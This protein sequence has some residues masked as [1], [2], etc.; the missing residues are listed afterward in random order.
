MASISSGGLDVQAIVAQLMV[1]EQKKLDGLNKSYTDDKVKISLYGKFKSIVDNLKTASDN[2]GKAYETSAYKVTSSDADKITAT[3]DVNKNN[4]IYA[5]KHT[6]AVTKL[7][8]AGVYSSASAY[9]T[10]SAAMNVT[11]NLTFT[12]GSDNFTIDVLATDTLEMVRDKINNA[13]SGAGVKASILSTTGGG[14]SDE[15]KLVIASSA[16]GTANNVSI[17]G[18][19]AATFNVTNVVSAAQNAEFTFDSNSVVRS[20]NQIN[21][22]LDGLSFNLLASGSTTT[23]T[24]D[25]DLTA[26][27]AAVTTAIK[28]LVTAYNNVIDFIDQATVNEQL[29]DSAVSTIKMSIRNLFTNNY[30]LSGSVTSMLDVG[31][32]KTENPVILQTSK[33]KDFYSTR[34][35]IKDDLISKALA[36][37]PDEVKRFFTDSI[38]GFMAAAKKAVEKITV[39]GT[40]QAQVTSLNEK[41]SALTQSIGKE[42]NRLE[43]VEKKLLIKYADLNS[44]ISR[45]DQISSFLDSQLSGISIK[46]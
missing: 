46:K 1:K 13:A 35:E 41:M 37:N 43:D 44:L 4:N 12:V 34:Y 15:F 16:T 28:N 38:D 17:T 24:I 40:I 9:T 5:G 25:T 8:Q 45:S 32:R 3:L 20:S 39:G 11:G 36:D 26:Q 18:T 22:V 6:I 14:G 27:N 7:A 21:D 29:T 10:K 23:L 31:M 2:V 42:E 30:D 19:A 33:G